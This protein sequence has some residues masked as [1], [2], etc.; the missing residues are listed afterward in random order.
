[1]EVYELSWFRHSFKRS[2]AAF[3]ISVFASP[4][5]EF[6][7][8]CGFIFQKPHGTI[9]I[10]FHFVVATTFV[11]KCTVQLNGA[12]LYVSIIFNFVV[13]N[14]YVCKCTVCNWMVCIFNVSHCN[15]SKINFLPVQKLCV[16]HC[17]VQINRIH[18]HQLYCV[19][20]ILKRQMKNFER[21]WKIGI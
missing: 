19:K 6:R 3:V 21:D 4:P 20:V 10:R 17:C 14:F 16:Q 2:F 9:A 5:K 1:M 11:C 13:C 12:H 8:L 18:L 7:Y 15:V